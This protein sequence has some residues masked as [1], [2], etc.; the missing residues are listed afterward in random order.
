[1]DQTGSSAL[2]SPTPSPPPEPAPEAQAPRP[3]PPPP[4]QLPDFDPSRLSPDNPTPAPPLPAAPTITAPPPD[5]AGDSSPAS[6][7][8]PPKAPTPPPLATTDLSPPLPTGNQ[9][10]APPPP[11]PTTDLSP[12]LPTGNQAPAPPPPLPTTD[13]SPPLPTLNQAPAP[14]LRPPPPPPSRPPPPPPPA[15]ASPKAKSDQ[16]AD[17][18]AGESENT[19]LALALTQAEEVVPQKAAAAESPAGSPQKESALTIA[20][21]LSGEDPAAKEAKTAT[22]K[23]APAVVTEPVAGGGGGGGGGVGSKRWLLRGVSGKGRRTEL[24]KA[25]LGFRVSAAVFC[26]VSLSVMSAGTT[27][28]WAGDSFRRYNEYRYMLAASVMAFTY[29]GFQL[30]AEVN[31]L[32]TG[33]RI[34]GGPW[35]N[36]FSLAMDQILAYLLLSA[37][38]AALSRSDVWVSRFG[39][40]QFAKLINSS[41]SM[42]FLA[43]IA[44]GLS[45]I[46]SAHRVFSSAS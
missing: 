33:R 39:V 46:I 24:Q 41:A 12:P 38:S 19:T 20:K 14:P 6:S 27:P 37:S 22:D 43:F 5:G 26:L 28:G 36:Y 9:A 10:P 21:L 23:V 29:S 11:L 15:P 1:M 16:E 2:A 32:V 4:S 40:D 13:L 17:E 34:I 35:G 18:S 7:P 31:Y 8:S 25:E 45:S 44:L 42:A 3:P 30:V